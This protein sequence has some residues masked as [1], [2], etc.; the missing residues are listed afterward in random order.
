MAIIGVVSDAE[1][2]SDLLHEDLVMGMSL[3]TP[4]QAMPKSAP[5]T[6][7][8]IYSDYSDRSENKNFLF[9]VS[10]CRLPGLSNQSGA[11]L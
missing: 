4:W 5:A 6:A 1:A 10:A 11:G 9:F 3:F 2:A 7:G 8:T